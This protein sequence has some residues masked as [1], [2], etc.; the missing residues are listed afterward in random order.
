M[1]IKL[2]PG[3]AA[4]AAAAALAGVLPLQ[5]DDTKQ[6]TTSQVAQTRDIQPQYATTADTTIRLKVNITQE[7][8]DQA[9]ERVKASKDGKA[10]EPPKQD[11]KQPS[12]RKAK[13]GKALTLGD[14]Y[15]LAN[16]RNQQAKDHPYK[17]FG[18]AAKKS[19]HLA[20]L[21]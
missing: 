5:Q 19:S 10:P 9:R 1:R 6:D 4:I 16:E 15:K 17:D 2:L 21:R 7:Q 3:I 8:I 13:D 20:S 14:A 18:R 11:S 12:E